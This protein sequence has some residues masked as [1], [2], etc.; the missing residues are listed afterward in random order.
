MIHSHNHD[1]HDHGYDHGHDHHGHGHAHHGHGHGHHGHGHAVTRLSRAFTIGLVLN[2]G[3]VAIEA[4]YGILAH[5]VALLA[6]AGHNLSDVLG[7][8][9]AWAAVILSRRP[10][11]QRYT[12]GWRR[13][14]ILAAFLNAIFLLMVTGG[15]AWESVQRFNQPEPIQGQ[16]MIGVAV[17]GIAINTITALMFMSGRKEDMNIRAAFLHMAADALV[18]VGVVLAGIGIVLTQWLWLDPVFSLAISL[19]IILNTWHLLRDS[20]NLAIDAVPLGVDERAVRVY[21]AEQPGVAEVH[22]LH[23][24]A[25]STTETA[26]TAHLIMPTGHPGDIFLAQLCHDLHERFRINHPTIQ[27]EIGDSDQICR[28]APDHHV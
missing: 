21:L 24:W 18:S 28:L 6:D 12:Y 2:L 3:F 15:I 5:S 13:S 16:V 10:P 26:L 23:I 22:D 1:H 11:S 25:L 14:S 27:I 7:L 9:L 19:L 8:V 20:F 4:V 17:V